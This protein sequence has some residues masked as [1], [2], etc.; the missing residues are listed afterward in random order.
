MLAALS[1]CGCHLF[2]EYKL[3]ANVDI[4]LPPGVYRRSTR[5]KMSMPDIATGTQCC[6][7]QYKDTQ[8][9][10]AVTDRARDY[11]SV[12]DTIKLAFIFAGEFQVYVFRPK[13]MAHK[14]DPRLSDARTGKKGLINTS[15]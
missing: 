7:R 9:N 3:W 11:Y 6:S 15:I 4:P 13:R 5:S 12:S 8:R 2:I 10:T 1:Q 14:K